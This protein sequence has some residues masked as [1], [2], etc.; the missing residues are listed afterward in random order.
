[1]RGIR[2]CQFHLS[3]NS[4]IIHTWVT[5][6][7][8]EESLFK[9]FSVLKLPI[10]DDFKTESVQKVLASFWIPFFNLSPKDSS[11]DFLS[12]VGVSEHFSKKYLIPPEL[13]FST[14][15]YSKPQAIN[16]C[17]KTIVL[18]ILKKTCFG[19]MVKSHAKIDHFHPRIKL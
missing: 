18:S 6:D 15:Y 9:T 19:E 13:L 14:D 11:W 2:L 4:F 16:Y 7:I 17:L 10:W 12:P 8:D 5:N 3:V 1:M